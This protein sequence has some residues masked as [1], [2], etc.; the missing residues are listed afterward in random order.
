MAFF[1]LKLDIKEEYK[2]II[3][4]YLMI[5]PIFLSMMLLEDKVTILSLF[6]YTILG[7]LVYQ[8]VI[9]ELINIV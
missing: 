1:D 6:S 7:T 4:M 5:L 2:E 9:K 8:L 3:N